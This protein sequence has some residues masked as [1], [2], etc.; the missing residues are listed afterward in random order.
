MVVIHG[1]CGVWGTL[2]IPF[3]NNVVVEQMGQATLVSQITGVSIA[4]IWSFGLAY[5]LFKTIYMVKL[6]LGKYD[7]ENKVV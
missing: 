2:A 4:F 6:K 3:T 1:L 5:L 7:N